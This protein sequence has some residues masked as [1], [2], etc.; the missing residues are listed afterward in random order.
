MKKSRKIRN[1]PNLIYFIMKVDI[2]RFGY[3]NLL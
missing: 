3:N 2:K 1:N